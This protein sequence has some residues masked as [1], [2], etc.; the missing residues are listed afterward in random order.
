[1]TTLAQKINFRHLHLKYCQMT[2]ITWMKGV[3]TYCRYTIINNVSTYL[4][5]V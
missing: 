2:Q 3:M 1:M 4:G 5:K